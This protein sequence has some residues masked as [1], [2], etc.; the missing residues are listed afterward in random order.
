MGGKS[1][2]SMTPVKT[3]GGGVKP[4]PLLAAKIGSGTGPAVVTPPVSSAAAGAYFPRARQRR[5]WRKDF[6]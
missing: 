1:P 3:V 2:K 5:I 6:R 4:P